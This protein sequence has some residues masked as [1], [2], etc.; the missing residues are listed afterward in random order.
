MAAET[1]AKELD[2]KFMKDMNASTD[3]RNTMGTTLRFVANKCISSIV[4]LPL[5]YKAP[6]DPTTIMSDM[7][8]ARAVTEATGQEY[9]VF[10]ADQ[11]L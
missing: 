6:A 11:Q 3:C 5:I 10:T 4:Y 1:R 7:L 8:K 9:M 2:F